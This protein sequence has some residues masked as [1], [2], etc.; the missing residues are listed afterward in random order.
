ML[1]ILCV[2]AY[3]SAMCM[4]CMH[5]VYLYMCM[6]TYTVCAHFHIAHVYVLHV[7]NEHMCICGI[8]CT[9]TSMHASVHAP[10]V[11]TLA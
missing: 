8:Y 2:H 1:C 7:F 6:F 3:V 10:V 9:C 11:W 4:F 5:C